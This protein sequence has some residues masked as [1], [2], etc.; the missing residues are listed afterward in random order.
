[1]KL[2]LQLKPFN[3]TEKHRSWKSLTVML[4]QVL[5]R[6]ITEPPVTR[7]RRALEE[8]GKL[9]NTSYCDTVLFMIPATQSRQSFA[10]H[11]TIE[12]NTYDMG[13]AFRSLHL[14]MYLGIR[15]FSSLPSTCPI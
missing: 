3:L 6:Q 5:F 10:S 8:S 1:M 12:D 4:S 11:S 9:V 13:L 14:A 15:L 7:R 2:K